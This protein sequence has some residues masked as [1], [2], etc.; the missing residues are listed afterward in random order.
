MVLTICAKTVL[1]SGT[2]SLGSKST[3]TRVTNFESL[4]R[5]HEGL[6]Y[7]YLFLKGHWAVW[8]YELPCLEL[9]HAR[10]LAELHCPFQGVIS[11]RW[12]SGRDSW[13]A[14]VLWPRRTLRLFKAAAE[15]VLRDLCNAG[16]FL[17]KTF[18]VRD[19]G[20]C[21]LEGRF[22]EALL[23][24]SGLH[25]WLHEFKCLGQLNAFSALFTHVF[26]RLVEIL[27]AILLALL[28]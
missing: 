23:A 6:L 26:C 14:V 24:E 20:V 22:E 18:A 17:L 15:R 2:S 11:V 28:D 13:L 3:L 27:E 21:R 19:L 16:L 1:S 25:F 12:F 5:L 8:L 7:Y 10:H 9:A 4:L